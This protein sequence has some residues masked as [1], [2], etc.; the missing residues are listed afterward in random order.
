MPVVFL[1]GVLGNV[2]E[3][4]AQKQ[5]VDIQNWDIWIDKHLVEH[6]IAT[7][8]SPRRTLRKIVMQQLMDSWFDRFVTQ[9]YT[10]NDTDK[11]ITTSDGTMSGDLVVEDL[12]DVSD[13]LDDYISMIISRSDA[14]QTLKDINKTSVHITSAVYDQRSALYLFQDAQDLVEQ[15]YTIVSHRARTNTDPG[16]RRHNISTAFAEFGHVRV[17]AP[18]EKVKFLDE[19]GYDPVE[20]EKY[21]EWYVI[22][23]DEE[24]PEYGGG[25]CGASTAL[26]QWVLTNTA[27]APT[28]WRAHTKRYGDLYNA[29]INDEYVSV[30]GI[31]STIYDGHID[32]ELTNTAPY[33]IV[34]VLNYD[35]SYGGIEEV[36]SLA[37]S[38]DIWSYNLKTQ[39]KNSSTIY[40]DGKPKNVKWGCYVWEVNGEERQSCYKEVH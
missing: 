3:V 8:T 18:G 4:Q 32:F 15:W 14:E 16:Y 25:L 23:Q 19:I 9:P 10:N 5:L 21:M 6:I 20:W 33:P 29:K 26:Y 7:D 28:E 2:L 27:L 40:V 30:P 37:K 35:W 36:F 22:V 11:Y 13:A 39:R 17:L 31:D 34:L 24:Q 38:Q 1:F 12:G